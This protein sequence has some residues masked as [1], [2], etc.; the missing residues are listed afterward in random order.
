LAECKPALAFDWIVG[1]DGFESAKGAAPVEGKIEHF[2]QTPI[3]PEK[4]GPGV[5]SDSRPGLT[6]ESTL[7]HST[8][9]AEEYF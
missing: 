3:G 1:K 6:P 9:H 5:F 2:T 8:G 7:Y 4:M